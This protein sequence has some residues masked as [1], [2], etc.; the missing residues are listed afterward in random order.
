MKGCSNIIPAVIYPSNSPS[1][2]GAIKSLYPHGI[3]IIGID[4][5]RNY[6]R[7]S[8]KFRP[9]IVPGPLAE[10]DAFIDELV[11]I[12]K[13]IGKSV[14]FTSSDVTLYLIC[15]NRDLLEKYFYYPFLDKDSLMAGLDK[16][17]MYKKAKDAG[18]PAP[19]TICPDNMKGLDAF[20]LPFPVIVKP[21]IPQFVIED[22][23]IGKAGLFLRE[24]KYAKA[25][26]IT[27]KNSLR[28]TCLKLFDAGLKFIVQE[29]IPGTCD[30]L[31]ESKYYAARNG[32]ICGI[33]VGRKIRQMP[34]DFGICSLGCSLTCDQIKEY[35]ERYV[36]ASGCW[37]MGQ[38]EF[39]YDRR[40]KI[41]KFIEIN[42]R[43]T[44]WIYATTFSGVNLP[45]LYYNDL[46]GRSFGEAG[47]VV[48]EIN[49]MH[50]ES[51]LSFFAK[52][53]LN[54]SRPYYTP[55]GVWLKSI[56]E[57]PVT[58]A[59]L[60]WDDPLLS[61][62]YVIRC[63]MLFCAKLAKNIILNLTGINISKR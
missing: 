50:F 57:R 23:K 59:F 49:W 53:C 56:F 25:L 37:G 55:P 5:S 16:W 31:H 19:L 32:R 27:D 38:V 48:R 6:V 43:L 29:E 26:R 45:L 4:S 47:P 15:R 35:T 12:G 33:F 34:P 42:A 54:K 11:G 22:G 41:F 60:A 30:Q 9:E 36:R 10:P 2:F 17:V 20:D 8:R 3:P 24:N 51:D 13:R 7:L 44:H 14:L 58:E 52:Y 61:M 39:K 46:T 62:F 63:L 18:L 40:D 1:G 21:S 28:L